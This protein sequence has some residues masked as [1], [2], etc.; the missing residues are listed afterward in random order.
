MGTIGLVILAKHRGVINSVKPVL[1]KIK[2]TD[3]RISADLELFAL[4]EAKE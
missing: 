3:F 1:E 4:S 2:T